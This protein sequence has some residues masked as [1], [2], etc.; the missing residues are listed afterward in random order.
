MIAEAAVVSY[1]TRGF[2]C[3]LLHFLQCERRFRSALKSGPDNHFFR[4]F[5]HA[6]INFE[7]EFYIPSLDQLQP[8]TVGWE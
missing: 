6:E 8:G 5:L 4:R 1:L 2:S 3:A 7:F